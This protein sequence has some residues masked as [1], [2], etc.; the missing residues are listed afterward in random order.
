[1]GRKPSGKYEI[2]DMIAKIIAYTDDTS[3]PILKEICYQNHWD[4][5]YVMN[6]QA[7]NENL[8]E[9]IRRLLDKKEVVLERG[10]LTGGLDKTM[11]IFSL[12]QLGWTDRVVNDTDT[13]TLDRVLDVLDAVREQAKNG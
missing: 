11:A 7:A 4:Y 10:G 12:K 5:Q 3:L 1:M 13:T 8:R 9:P 6:L 2:P